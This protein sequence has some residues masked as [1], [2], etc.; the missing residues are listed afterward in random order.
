MKLLTK[1]LTKLNLQVAHLT[2][3]DLIHYVRKNVT[4]YLQLYTCQTAGKV[5]LCIRCSV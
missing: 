1:L 4:T 2:K 3:L 5:N